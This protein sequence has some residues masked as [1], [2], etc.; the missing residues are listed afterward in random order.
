VPI[1]K[2]IQTPVPLSRIEREIERERYQRSL[3]DDVKTGA[4]G[5]DSDRL[6]DAR[7]SFGS[8]RPQR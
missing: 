6:K 7:D 4:D 2:P 1:S 3:N 5:H 8:T